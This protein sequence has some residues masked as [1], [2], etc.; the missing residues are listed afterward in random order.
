M[1]LASYGVCIGT[2]NHFG[3]DGQVGHWLHGLVF[4]NLP[5]RQ[6][7][8]CAVDVN[9]TTAPVQFKIIYD[10]DPAAFTTIANLPD[11]YHDLPKTSASGAL[12][13]IR[14]TVLRPAP[15]LGNG[16][17]GC[18]L[19]LLQLLIDALAARQWTTVTG[20]EAN[21]ALQPLV[22]NSQRIFVFGEPFHN[23]D[24]ENGMHNI[25]MNQGDPPGPHQHDDAI[26][27]DGATVVL[28]NDGRLI[29][30]LNKFTT[31]SLNTNDNGLPQ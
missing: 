28:S 13:Y 30:F 19:W 20:T 29:A 25:H 4:L 16:L 10:L 31:Q 8:R 24:G 22:T 23:A 14:S 21:D 27:Q 6:V 9:G 11:G 5:Q 7:W 1:P 3:N 12:D 2:L 17:A 18:V 15:R 26:W